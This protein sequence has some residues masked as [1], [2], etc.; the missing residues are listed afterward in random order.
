MAYELLKI[1]YIENH[2]SFLYLNRGAML[3]EYILMNAYV[4]IILYISTKM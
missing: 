4:I 1:D 3:I 2:I